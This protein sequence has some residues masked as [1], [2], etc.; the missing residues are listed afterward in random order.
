MKARMI[1]LA[2]WLCIFVAGQ[3]SAGNPV[4][5]VNGKPAVTQTKFFFKALKNNEKVHKGQKAHLRAANVVDVGQ[6]TVP[7]RSILEPGHNSPDSA[8]VH[9]EDYRDSKTVFSY[10]GNTITEIWYGKE[11]Y[12]DDETYEWIETGSWD[13]QNY[14][15]EEY[16]FDANGNQILSVES[17]Y[18]DNVLVWSEKEEYV[19]NSNNTPLSEKYYEW[20]DGQW[21][22]W[23]EVSYQYDASGMLIGGSMYEDGETYLITASGT[24]ENLEISIVVDGMTVAKY[25]RHYDPAS[26]KELASEEYYLSEEGVLEFSYSYKYTYDAAG[27]LTTVFINGYD[28][29][30]EKYEYAYNANGKI[31]SETELSADTPD[32]PY[33]TLE[34]KTEYVYT[35][36]RL[37]KIIEYNY[38]EGESHLDST[39]TF[40]YA[41]GSSGN[42][43]I[44][45]AAA[46]S[47]H[48]SDGYVTVVLPEQTAY[49]TLQLIDLSGQ[50]VL[51]TQVASGQPVA[52]QSL[53]DGVYIYRILAG[54]N[55]YGKIIIRK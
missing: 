22:L 46:L 26:M 37:E 42:E 47:I 8:I 36:D 12:Y 40:Y 3:V 51:K 16:A 7:L 53:P 19:Y 54:A 24:L 38:Y 21:T 27:R 20:E 43:S 35:N 49:A 14:Y 6:S 17:D 29:Y 10:N 33:S 48:A 50:T 41:G 15:Q 4:K 31:I 30:Y 23:G 1:L 39:T 25:V 18:E 2:V 55:A 32:G 5:Q 9:N 11:G 45:A 34:W 52:V 28:S 44:K 13:T